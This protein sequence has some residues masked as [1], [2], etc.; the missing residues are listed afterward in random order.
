MAPA[1][2]MSTP[3]SQQRRWRIAHAEVRRA[4]NA[5]DFGSVVRICIAL[6]DEEC[7]LVPTMHSLTIPG[8]RVSRAELADA[9]VNLA[10]HIEAGK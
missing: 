7:A 9:L 6:E 3:E 4:D 10:A 5:K 8:E 2:P 1:T